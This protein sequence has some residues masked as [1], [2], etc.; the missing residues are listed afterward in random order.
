MPSTITGSYGRA[1]VVRTAGPPDSVGDLVKR[2]IWTVDRS[3][4]LTQPGSLVGFLQRFSYAGPRLVLMVLGVFAGLGLV[5]VALGVFSVIAY[6]VSRQTHDIGIRM[7]LGAQRTDVLR[8]VLRLGLKL[9]GAGVA[10]GS[11]PAW[12]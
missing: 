8:M 7:A 4:A 10:L 12:D 5:L 11:R 3:V 6:T 9:V 2:E 1:V